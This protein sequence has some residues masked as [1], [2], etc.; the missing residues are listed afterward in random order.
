M[1]VRNFSKIFSNKVD[2]FVYGEVDR[3]VEYEPHSAHTFSAEPTFIFS[4]LNVSCSVVFK[5]FLKYS[6]V[7]AETKAHLK[8][9]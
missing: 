7:K 4:I 3:G 2:I 9:K 6:H 1:T 5:Y 8:R